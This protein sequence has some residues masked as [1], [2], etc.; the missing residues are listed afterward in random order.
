MW[1]GRVVCK[2][3]R[4][5]TNKTGVHDQGW[6]TGQVSKPCMGRS[7]MRPDQAHKA[8]RQRPL[9]QLRQHWHRGALQ[10][11]INQSLGMAAR[12]DPTGTSNIRRLTGYNMTAVSKQTPDQ[13]RQLASLIRPKPQNKV[14]DTAKVV[15]SERTL[16]I[17]NK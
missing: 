1:C 6:R 14:L 2:T 11:T 13:N 16:P 9:R 5:S 12:V 8:Q 7:P 15:K 10:Q 4:S 17:R 3:Q